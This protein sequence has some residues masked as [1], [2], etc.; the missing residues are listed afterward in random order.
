MPGKKRLKGEE[1]REAILSAAAEQF[2]THGY[3]A[4]SLEGIARAM[5][6][7]RP[8]VYDYF[9]SKEALHLYLLKRE[10]DRIVE[11]V[12]GRLQ[13]NRVG[14]ARI[15][16][17]IDAFFS[18]VEQHPYAWRILFREMSGGDEVVE[19]HRRI[20]SEASSSLADFLAGGLGRSSGR[21]R[22]FLEMVGQFWGE[23]MR[24]LARWWYDH[25]S[26]KR[27]QVVEAATSALWMGLERLSTSNRKS[28]PGRK[29]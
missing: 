14:E 18:Y 20:Q 1:R 27:E 26:V 6:I 21:D 23:A 12:F 5:K 15:R 16:E 4:T 28:R 7:S 9:P 22:Q 24:G 11:H 25:P 10:R 19:A 17:G 3:A 29:R 8:V 2:A 13:G